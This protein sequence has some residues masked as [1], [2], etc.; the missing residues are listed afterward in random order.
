MPTVGRSRADLAE[1]FASH[2]RFGN[3]AIESLDVFDGD[4]S[5]WA[6][7]ER[8][9]DTGGFGAR[10]AA[11]VRASVFP[12]LALGLNGGRNDPRAGAFLDK[13]ETATAARLALKPEPTVIPLAIVVLAKEP[14]SRLIEERR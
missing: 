3:L 10:W 5:I 12:T 14:F 7:F 2:G 6:Q 8:D 1:P 11:F 4:D 9:G 13:L